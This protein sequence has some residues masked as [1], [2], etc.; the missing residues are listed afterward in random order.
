MTDH[1]IELYE[2]YLERL[3]KQLEVFKTHTRFLKSDSRGKILR[4]EAI[5]ILEKKLDQLYEAGSDKKI[6][7]IID[8]DE[9][10][11]KEG[12]VDRHVRK[13]YNGFRQ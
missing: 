2:Q 13:G 10:L 11:D 12:G 9:V 5:A 6:N 7:K 4:D 8:L 3:S 1:E